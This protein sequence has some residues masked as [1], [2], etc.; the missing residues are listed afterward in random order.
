VSSFRIG[1]YFVRHPFEPLLVR[2][3]ASPQ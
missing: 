2:L 3:H 1:A